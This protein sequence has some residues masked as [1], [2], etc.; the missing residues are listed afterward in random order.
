MT[1]LNDKDG[2]M[3]F[4]VFAASKHLIGGFKYVSFFR[5]FQSFALSSSLLVDH[6]GSS[7][8]S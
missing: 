6:S 5:D 1:C 7:H 3:V 8:R 4:D 2:T